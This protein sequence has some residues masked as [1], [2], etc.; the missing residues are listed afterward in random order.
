MMNIFSKPKDPVVQ[1]KEWTRSIGKDIRKLE[2]EIKALEREEAKMAKECKDLAKKNQRAAVNVL[3]KEIVR[4]RKAKENMYNSRA[5]MNNM[6]NQ[7]KMQ[8]A[9]TKTAGCMQ[10]SAEVM[11]VMNNLMQTG[12]MTADMHSLAREMEKA[13]M[14]EEIMNEGLE[15]IDGDDIEDEAAQEVD[16]VVSELTV[17]LFSGAEVVPEAIP[18]LPAEP[19]AAQAESVDPTETAEDSDMAAMRDRLEAL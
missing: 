13:G 9:I 14:I 16:K 17:G 8:L 7:M 19:G 4:A 11:G 3:A 6:S 5:M 10:R 2:R 15:Q 1:I 12:T 18:S